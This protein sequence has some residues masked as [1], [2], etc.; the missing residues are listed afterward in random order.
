MRIAFVSTTLSGLPAEYQGSHAAEEP[1]DLLYA[2]A[3]CEP[4]FECELIDVWA[5]DPAPRLAGIDAVVFSTTNSYLQWNNHPL[6]LGLF[7][8]AWNRVAEA[9]E[10]GSPPVRVVLGPHVPAHWRELYA[11][12]ADAVILGEAELQV[13][14][15][16]RALLSGQSPAGI[17]GYLDPHSRTRSAPARVDDLDAL[18]RPAWEH[19]VAGLY[20]AHNH[21]DST[22]LG[23]LYEASRGCPYQCSYCNTITHRRAFRA[24]SPAKVERELGHLATMSARRYVYFIDESFGFRDPW[25]ED[26]MPRLEALP[27]Q[28]GCQ[29]NLRFSSRA[30][31]DAMAKAGFVDV[32]FGFETGDAGL[33]RTV[34]KDNRLDDAAEIIE[35][36]AAVGLNPLLFVLLGLPGEDHH[37]LRRTF[38][39]LRRLPPAVRISVGMPTPYQETELHRIGVATGVL[40]RERGADLYRFTGTIGHELHFAPPERQRFASDYGPNNFLVPAFVDRLEHDAMRMFR[41]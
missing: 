11:M 19:T 35:H 37:S 29:G 18:C 4:S 41:S 14:V 34:G 5:D 1:L 27:F 40:G 31:L 26:L 9:L 39:F 12:G 28:Y 21:L 3:A 13:P 17:P 33:L 2:I 32:E 38:E 6:G 36:A 7:E 20:C 22:Q 8:R 23:H 25:V 10:P 30:K 16:L 24:K 15:V